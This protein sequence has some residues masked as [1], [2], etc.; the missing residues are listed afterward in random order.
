[1]LS[2]GCAFVVL[3]LIAGPANAGTGS[4][5]LAGRVL[6]AQGR[7]A[8]GVELSVIWNANGVSIDEVHK[9]EKGK[10]DP[11]LLDINEG[12]MEPWGDHPTR[13]DA[14]G[15]FSVPMSWSN[16]FLLALDRERKHG[17]LVVVDLP[18]SA[19]GVKVTLEPLVRLRGTVRLATGQHP[20]W[21][22]VIVCLPQSEKFPLRFNRVAVCSS[23]EQRFEFLLPA[24][25]YELDA[26]AQVSGRGFELE[27]FRPVTVTAGS[28]DVDAGQLELSPT[29][30]GRYQRIQEARS[31]G[32]WR[33]VDRTKLYGQ[34]APRWNAV[35]ARGIPKGAQVA[36]F[37]GKWVLVYFWGPWCRPCLGRH[38]PALMEFYEAQKKESDR[39]E[40]V[41]VCNSEPDIKT[42]A[43]LDRQLQP[44]VKA[45]WH[46]PLPFP[47]VLDN[48]LKT[49]ENFGVAGEKFL[50]DP[51]GRLVP[52]DENTL[53]EK[54][55]STER[56]GPKR[57][58]PKP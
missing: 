37:K 49:V 43:D 52:G 25:R 35:D 54:L 31:K 14:Q 40:I 39:F 19:S 3:V 34:P 2:R 15:R 44:V 8:V 22:N 53:A 12:R 47:I 50:F 18:V 11:H 48:T 26:G 23:L 13:S 42:L 51:A 10:G 6:D 33:D 27:P 5:T 16:G 24:G 56:D 7:P 17:A 58:D 55:K 29:R 30:P 41:T 4:W 45:V 32:T 9:I 36:D 38:L 46:Q 57:S 28:H 20:D 1:M 21:V